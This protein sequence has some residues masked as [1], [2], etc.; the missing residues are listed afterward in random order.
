MKDTFLNVFLMVL[1]GAGGITILLVA[2]LQP[3]PLVEIILTT[4]V[5]SIGIL[6]VVI[7]AVS[8]VLA[9]VKV[10]QPR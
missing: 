3:V 7:R 5:A 1:F 8:L 2:W 10:R 9:R 4:S 6:W